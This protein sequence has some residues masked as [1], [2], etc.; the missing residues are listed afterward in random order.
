MKRKIVKIHEEKCNGCGICVKACHEGAIEIVSGKAKLLSDIYCDGLGDCLPECPKG[1]IEIIEREAEDYSEE[2]V[3]EKAIQKNNNIA[4]GCPGSAAKTIIRKRTAEPLK[5]VAKDN[6]GENKSQLRQW[7]VQLNLI[8]T[9]APYLKGADLLVAAD[10]S[11][12]A[13]GKFHEDFIK[14]HITVI[15]CPKL[16]DVNYY[17]DKLTEILLNSNIKSITVV[18]MEVPCCGGI[19]AAVKSAMLSANT[20]VPYREVTISTSGEIL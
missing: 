8:N 6:N 18:R 14:D 3:K 2:A 20:I 13:Y 4:C 17:K 5:E 1:A 10:C 15:G 9:R 19:V 11:A 7:P 16:D 12:Y